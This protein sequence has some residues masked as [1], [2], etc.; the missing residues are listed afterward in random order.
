L[1]L[2]DEVELAI[3]DNRHRLALPNERVLREGGI[4]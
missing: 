2:A 4:R 1:H 3:I